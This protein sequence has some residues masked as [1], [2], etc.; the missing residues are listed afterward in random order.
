MFFSYDYVIASAVF[1]D[2][3]TQTIISMNGRIYLLNGNAIMRTGAHYSSEDEH[4]SPLRSVVARQCS[5]G[6]FLAANP[7]GLRRNLLDVSPFPESH[8]HI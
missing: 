6:V 4:L 3:A 5:N 8:G 2:R 1:D 7:A